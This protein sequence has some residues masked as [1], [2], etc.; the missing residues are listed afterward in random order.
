MSLKYLIVID[1]TANPTN[2]TLTRIFK[3]LWTNGLINAHVLTANEFGSWSLDTFFPYRSDC[4]ELDHAR[5]ASFTPTNFTE[6]IN[7]SM[8]QLY[9]K[10]LKNFNR[11]PIFVAATHSSVYVIRNTT[12]GIDRYRGIDINIIEQIA[13]TLNF[14]IV[15][16]PT[17]RHGDVFENGTLTGSI[18]LVRIQCIICQI[19]NVTLHDSLFDR[20]TMVM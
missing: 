11:C 8:K 3:V 13:K 16:K 17:D 20:Y 2:E 6:N 15:Y 18:K 12:N 4:A 10:K 1:P 5:I 19:L 7:L 9:P 14:R